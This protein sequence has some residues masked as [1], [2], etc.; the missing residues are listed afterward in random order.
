M[1][2]LEIELI[3]IADTMTLIAVADGD[4]YIKMA[5]FIW[6]KYTLTFTLIAETQRFFLN[7]ALVVFNLIQLFNLK[8]NMRKFIEDMKKYMFLNLAKKIAEFT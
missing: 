8:P 6:I 2:I 5:I 7:N 4:C 3:L 1:R